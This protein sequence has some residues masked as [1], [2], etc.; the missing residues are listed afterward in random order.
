MLHIDMNSRKN[1]RGVGRRDFVRV[2]A[3]STLG[4]SMTD[5]FRAQADAADSDGV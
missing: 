4:L 2:G 5:L 1:R 3:L